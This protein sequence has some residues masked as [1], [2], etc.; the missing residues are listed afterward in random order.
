MK[1]TSVIALFVGLLG[2][3][4]RAGAEVP[5]L[6]TE[7]PLLTRI[8][9]RGLQESE[10]F[11]QLYQRLESSNLI[12]HVQRG[13]KARAGAAFNQF[14]AQV[15]SYRFVR[16]TINVDSNTDDAVALL[17]HELRH[18]VEVADTPSVEDGDDYER[19]YE[20][21]GYLSCQAAVPR[22]YETE[23]A[24]DA[25]RAVLRELKRKQP[26]GVAAALAAAQLIRRWVGGGAPLVNTGGAP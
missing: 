4:V 17:G 20:R 10:T 6:R 24:V 26:A 23:A 5:C 12:V 18:A 13:A 3:A 8:V 14:V 1:D 22:C 9:T 25:G 19:L 21:I 2:G 16:I 11:R 15:G 7:D